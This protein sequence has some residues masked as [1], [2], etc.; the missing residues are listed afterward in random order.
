MTNTSP[1]WIVANLGLGEKFTD[2]ATLHLVAAKRYFDDVAL[3]GSETFLQEIDNSLL[4]DK[5]VVF[6]DK[7]VALAALLEAK[8][9]RVV[10]SSSAITIC[11]DKRLTGVFLTKARVPVPRTV[12]LPAL[13]PKQPL[14]TDTR[15][16]LIA[17]LGLPFVIKEAKGSFGSQVYLIETA[18][19]LDAVAQTLADRH[20]LAQ[21]F[22]T[23]SYGTDLRLQVVGDDVVAAM[24]R[25][26]ELD[27]RANLSNG[28]SGTPHTP[29]TREVELAIKACRAV[30]AV[31]AGV[32]LLVDE[33][34]EGSL[35]CEVN[36]NAHIRR[37]SSI[38]EIDCAAKLMEFLART[39]C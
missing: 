38:T 36:S 12:L 33:H 8:G 28:G 5:V 16:G 1:L 31:S 39:S 17:A 32:D 6:L 26:N 7:D 9:A 35:V 13:Y 25:H 11:D 20:L 29:T 21:E 24:R 15:K 14:E 22:V 18:E 19:D 2:H 23:S 37:L 10:N 30:G 27:F 3:I 34:G 4:A